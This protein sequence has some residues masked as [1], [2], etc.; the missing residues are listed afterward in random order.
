[1]GESTFSNNRARYG[2][3]FYLT[4]NAKLNTSYKEV[5]SGNTASYDGGAIYNNGIVNLRNVTLDGNIAGQGS[6]GGISNFG[7]ATLEAATL[8]GNSASYGGGIANNTATATLTM[9]NVTLSGNSAAATGGAIDTAN[10]RATLTNVTL[11]G[12]SARRGGGIFNSGGMV[13]LLNTLLAHG[14]NG[15]NCVNVTGSL[16]NFS[17]SDDISCS[18]GPGRDNL[19][20][21]LGPL[22]N[23]GGS[24]LTHLPLPGSPAIDAGTNDGAPYYDQRGVVRPRDGNGDGI[25]RADVGAVEVQSTQER[26]KLYLPQVQR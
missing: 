10:S 17:L 24:M 1:M 20:L 19:N 18:F 21:R 15:A 6:G 8:S 4:S 2:G 12:N 22:A 16:I 26:P 25:A 5:L 11:S 3:A 9:T 14:P 7:S 23:N 13:T